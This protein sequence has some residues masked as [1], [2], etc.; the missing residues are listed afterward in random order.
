M[1]SAAVVIGV[2][3]TKVLTGT[4]THI[5]LASFCGTL[6]NSAKPDQTHQNAASD[7]VLHC[8][9]TEVSRLLLFNASVLSN[10][11]HVFTQNPFFSSDVP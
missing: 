10:T 3:K 1:S 9:L 4:L 5:S 7:Q 8:L 2:S 6:A 11:Y